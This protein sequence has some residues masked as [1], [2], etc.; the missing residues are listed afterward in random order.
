[1]EKPRTIRKAMRTRLWPL[2]GLPIIFF[3][4]S[5]LVGVNGPGG[6][7]FE[8]WSHKIPEMIVSNIRVLGE[9]GNMACE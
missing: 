3:A 7:A 4:L 8:S 2:T 5:V 6:G 1:M 9:D